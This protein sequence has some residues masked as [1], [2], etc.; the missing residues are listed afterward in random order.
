MLLGTRALLRRFSN[1]GATT[2]PEI[3]NEPMLNYAPGSPERAKIE[4]AV[5]SMKKRLPVTIPCVIGG[6]EVHGERT[7]EQRMPSDHAVTVARFTEATPAMIND[8]IK[9]ALRAREAWE[10]FPVE[11]RIAV[12]LRAGDLAA[13]KHRWDILA[14]TMLG[15]GKNVWQA[16]I[17]AAAEL[18]DFWRFNAKFAQDVYNMQPARNA[19]NAWNRLEYL[20]L[21]GFVA[22]ITPFNFTAIGGNLPASPAIMGNTVVW[23]PAPNAMLS[24]YIVYK[25]LLEAGLPP[26]VINFVPADGPGFANEVMSSP[27]LAGIHFTGSTAVFESIL[28]QT[29]QNVSKYR[30]FPRIVGETGGKNFHFVHQSANIDNAVNQTIRGAFEYS[31]QKCSATS[32]LYVPN[33]IWKEFRDKLVAG[34]AGIKIGQPDDFSTFVS[35]VI[36]GRSFDK[37]VG[38]IEQARSS[39]SCEII[40]GGTYD[41]SRGY[42]V[43]PTVIL[44]TDP[45]YASM[46]QEIFGPILTVFVYDASK[47][48]ETLKLCASTSPYGLTGGIF[49][50]DRAA[51]AEAKWVLRHSAGN[52]Y[53]N[54]KSTGAIV[55]QQAFGG[56]RKSGTNDKSGSMLNLL[57]WVSARVIKD[58]SI[59]L[60]SYSYP[61][62]N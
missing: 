16:E 23:K 5:V 11:D 36:D 60:T 62:M 22:A 26:E 48:S 4:A 12:F 49:A 14:A 31:G 32:R 57:R 17:D 55:G 40:A 47:F 15:Q 10:R 34:I 42:F 20:P 56:S 59:P 8:A 58:T 25:V 46:Q 44:T 52:L 35:A 6:K 54:D 37:C 50:T 24:N 18:V 39:K 45:N 41:K 28:K 13:G 53:L 33:T 21:E 19:P 2:L 43:H 3:H 9:S 7:V 29:A 51:M 61:H 1:F 38:F 27:D 30:Q